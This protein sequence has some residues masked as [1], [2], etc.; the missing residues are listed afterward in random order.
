[1]EESRKG[2]PAPGQDDG[3]PPIESMYRGIRRIESSPV[4]AGG[5]MKA[6]VVVIGCGGSGIPAAVAAFE[7]EPRR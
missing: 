2:S 4:P 5:V 7:T 1:M 3:P 6:D